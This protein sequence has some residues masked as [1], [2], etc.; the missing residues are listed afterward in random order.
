MAWDVSAGLRFVRPVARLRALKL[1]IGR[2]DGQSIRYRLASPEV[3]EVLATLHRMYCE[4]PE[5]KELH[6]AGSR[7]R[8]TPSSG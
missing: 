7:D 1:V 8:A 2:R 5:A 6:G 3:A 4:P